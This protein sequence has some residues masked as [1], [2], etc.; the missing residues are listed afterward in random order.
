MKALPAV[1]FQRVFPLILVVC[2]ICGGCSGGLD[3]DEDSSVWLELGGSCDSVTY[4]SVEG[5]VLDKGTDWL[6]IRT[7][8]GDLALEIDGGANDDS[9]EAL[10]MRIGEIVV[11]DEVFASYHIDG[12]VACFDAIEKK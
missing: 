2:L 5:R 9:R 3:A 6:R 10:Q 8:K 7:D 1:R 11:G 4:T 12:S